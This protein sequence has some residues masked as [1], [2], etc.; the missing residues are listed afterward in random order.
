MDTKF[1]CFAFFRLKLQL[2]Y[3]ESSLSLTLYSSYNGSIIK[4]HSVSWKRKSLLHFAEARFHLLLADVRSL[5]AEVQHRFADVRSLFAEV[6]HRFAD[7]RSLFAEVRHR[8]LTVKQSSPIV[9]PQA[10]REQS[11]EN[12]YLLQHQK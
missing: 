12:C 3:P 7:V 6:R 5:F 11:S 2:G 8:C 10:P 4:L 1:V 9:V